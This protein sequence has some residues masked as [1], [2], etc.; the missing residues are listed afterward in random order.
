MLTPP[1]PPSRDPP[2]RTGEIVA[3][4]HFTDRAREVAV[5]SRALLSSGRL[6]LTGERR[7]GK[8][9]ILR[10]AS[11]HARARGSTV[12]A[13]DLW[14]A[15][16]LEEVLRRIVASVPWGWAWRERLQGLWLGLGLSL[17][18]RADTTGA[19]TFTL[20]GTPGEIRGP[21]A[22]ELFVQLIERLD[23]VAGEAGTPVA[24][25]LDEF[26]RLEDVDPGA[27]ALLR[28]VIQ[29]SHH[30][31]YVCAG[32]AI[33]LVG[34]LIGP[35]GPL[36]GIFDEVAV[37]PI[38]A[39]LLAS[40]IEDRLRSHGVTPAAGTGTA[41][42][43]WAGPRTEDV[44]RLAREVWD[45]GISRGGTAP[46]DVPPAIRRIVLDRRSTYER[47]WVDLADSQRSVLRALADGAVQLTARDTLRRYAL[48]TPAG[49]RK[50]VTRLQHLQLVNASGDAPSDPFF[51]EWILMRAMPDGQSH[52]GLD[53]PDPGADA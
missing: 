41:I 28:S 43:G 40:W 50:A 45:G 21:R 18:V 7:L 49:V 42:V 13:L 26:Q 46:D 12:I 29:N 15:A 31:A 10:Q 17:G 3:D 37:G 20:A 30:L 38:D 22:R 51:A 48:P 32:S 33:S 9:S 16:S 2:F 34:K 25:V 47:V 8:S 4:E 27:G 53:H 36:H 23:A 44:L 35:K 5:T 14:T 6:V 39:D 11:L 52:S 24:L 19:P 1:S